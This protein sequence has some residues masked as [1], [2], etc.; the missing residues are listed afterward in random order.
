MSIKS[1][2]KEY[3]INIEDDLV[4][5]SDFAKKIAKSKSP[6]EFCKGI[7]RKKLYKFVKVGKKWFI[8]TDDLLKIVE[9]SSLKG[10]IDFKKKLKKN[11]EEDNKDLNMIDVVNN[12]YI[13]YGK[14]IYTIIEDGEPWFKAHDV[15][16]VLE[17]KN[18]RETIKIHVDI[19]FKKK[20][21]EFDRDLR[22]RSGLPLKSYNNY[23]ETD[24]QTIMINEPGLYSLIFKS[25]M[26]KAKEFVNWIAEEV[27]PSIRKTGSYKNTDR[28]MLFD[29]VDYEEYYCVYLIRINKNT[30]KYGDTYQIRQRLGSHNRT[31]DGF[32]LVK[33]FKFDDY[34]IMKIMAKRL[35]AYVKSIN[36]N[37]TDDEG[38]VELFKTTKEYDIKYLLKEFN[39]MYSNLTSFDETNNIND[40]IE[41]KTKILNEI[42]PKT[43][44]EII[45]KIL[46]KITE[47]DI[48]TLKVYESIIKN[49]VLLSNSTSKIENKN[50]H[51]QN[52][53]DEEYNENIEPFPE[54][55]TIE[56]IR[57]EFPELI[58]K[59]EMED[60]LSGRNDHGF[61]NVVKVTN[62]GDCEKTKSH[63]EKDMEKD[64]DNSDDADDFISED[65]IEENKEKKQKI[66]KKVKKVKKIENNIKTKKKK[67]KEP[68]NKRKTI[69]PSCNEN[70]MCKSSI[71][72]DPCRRK[73]DRKVKNRPSVKKLKEELK[74]S[75]YVA[76]GKKYGVTDNCI[77]KWIRNGSK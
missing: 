70:E 32:N 35:K 13:F 18:P 21:S 47:V 68:S 17:Y 30:Y 50:T 52:Y 12:V 43:T 61:T 27:L 8:N 33:V 54:D 48:D 26:K 56:E 5:F 3:G 7:R 44:N 72:C 59:S 36:I 71:M 65:E 24:S 76:V 16:N 2:I 67:V 74:N 37:Y 49:C 55:A 40:T 51:E 11:E 14:R 64:I 62:W 23:R 75:T 41:N 53:E 15:C 19:N 73:S 1:L 58:L 25:T 9:G 77:R 39:E 28:S 6:N 20:L 31:F 42:M 34:R 63:M 29:M 60:Y 66:V 38:R 10:C 45:N 22:G 69:C 46:G 57:K 4:L